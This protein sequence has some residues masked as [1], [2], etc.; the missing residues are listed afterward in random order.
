MEKEKAIELLKKTGALLEGHFLLT[1]GNHSGFYIQCAHLLSFPNIAREFFMD[2]AQHFKNIDFDTIV[3]PAIGGII[4]SY[5]VAEIMNKKSIFLERENNVFTLRRGFQIKKGEKILLV[6][7]VITTGGSII[8]VA[9]V[10][11]RLGAKVVGY[12][13][14]VNRSSGRFRPDEDYYYSVEMDFPIY[15]PSECPLCEENIPLVKH[16]SRGLK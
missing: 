16:G 1:S 14:I 3:G 2:I 7:D 10:L 13:S 9:K 11:K 8:E 4:V 6:E 15:K 12:A 5:G